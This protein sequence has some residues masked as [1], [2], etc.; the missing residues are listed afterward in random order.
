MMSVTR[1]KVPRPAILHE[2]IVKEAADAVVV[3][4][5]LDDQLS[6]NIIGIYQP[7]LVAGA[8]VNIGVPLR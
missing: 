2:R 4:I 1:L 6:G 3:G 5:S 8:V 7:Q